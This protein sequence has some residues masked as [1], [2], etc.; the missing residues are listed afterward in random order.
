MKLSWILSARP[1]NYGKSCITDRLERE[2]LEQREPELSPWL[3]Q[4]SVV[5]NISPK[6]GM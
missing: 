5:P 3:V 2:K 1:G 6:L 4:M